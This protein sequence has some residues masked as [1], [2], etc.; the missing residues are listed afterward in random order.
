[1]DKFTFTTVKAQVLKTIKSMR[2]AAVIK[3]F[4]IYYASAFKRILPFYEKVIRDTD[5][6]LIFDMIKTI[7]NNKAV[8]EALKE[9]LSNKDKIHQVMDILLE[10]V[11]YRPLIDEIKAYKPRVEAE[12]DKFKPDFEVLTE[13]VTKD[14]TKFSKIITKCIKL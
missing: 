14:A 13:K 3:A 6:Q 9:N 1:M 7:E 2:K 12:I 11:E 10:G 4:G 5:E 8:F